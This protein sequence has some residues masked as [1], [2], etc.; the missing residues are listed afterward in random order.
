MTTTFYIFALATHAFSGSY[1]P[2]Q[3]CARDGA[4]FCCADTPIKVELIRWGPK[5]QY[6]KSQVTIDGALTSRGT[7]IYVMPRFCKIDWKRVG[8]EE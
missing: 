1:I 4:L 7:K 6:I 3:Y 5:L 8:L 2:R